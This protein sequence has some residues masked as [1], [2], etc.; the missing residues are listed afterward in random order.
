MT[1]DQLKAISAQPGISI[2][3]NSVGTP[4]AIS[5]SIP[6]SLGGGYIVGDSSS[7]ESALLK[8]GIKIA[9]IAANKCVFITD[10]NAAALMD[11]AA[12]KGAMDGA[13]SAAGISA[14]TQ[15]VLAV[16]VA[17]AVAAVVTVVSSNN[18]TAVHH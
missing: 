15:T 9:N 11:T 13:V 1:A 5:I 18:T 7:F 4:G 8:T 16:G 17:A 6:V 3:P 12:E 2:L 10:S 14:G